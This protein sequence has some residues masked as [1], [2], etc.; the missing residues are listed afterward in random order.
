MNEG[1]GRKMMLSR[2]VRR[3]LT[4][5]TRFGTKEEIIRLEAIGE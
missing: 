1:R 4:R 5:R 2:D 3:S